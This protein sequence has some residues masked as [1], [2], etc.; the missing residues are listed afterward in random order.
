MY[1]IMLQNLFEKV[2]FGWGVR[3]TGFIS[4]VFCGIA[5]LT[6][7][8]TRPSG[9]KSI[10]G[11]GMNTFKDARF[12]LLAAGSSLVALGRRPDGP[13]DSDETS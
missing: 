3:I 9:K 10:P 5:V 7:T 2:G 11:L 6:V 1:P 8:S 13:C 4:F 12:I